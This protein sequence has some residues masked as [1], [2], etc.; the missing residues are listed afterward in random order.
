MAIG[1]NWGAIWNEAIWNTAIW[2]QSAAP[3]TKQDYTLGGSG[4]E[5][6]EYPGQINRT[7]ATLTGSGYSVPEIDGYEAHAEFTL[8]GSGWDLL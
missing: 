5:G 8:T 4:W 7:P 3:S 2:S 6:G 1:A